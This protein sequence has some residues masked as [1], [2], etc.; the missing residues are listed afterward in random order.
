MTSAF[1]T[2]LAGNC[3]SDTCIGNSNFAF[4]EWKTVSRSI[5]EVLT[6]NM[7]NFS[8][9]MKTWLNNHASDQQACP[10]ATPATS[11]AYAAAAK[12]KHIS[13]RRAPYGAVSRGQHPEQSLL[14]QS[15]TVATD[16]SKSEATSLTSDS[17][18]DHICFSCEGHSGYTSELWCLH[19]N[20][21]QI[22][23]CEA[24][25][26]LFQA[27]HGIQHGEISGR[28]IR[29]LQDFL[30]EFLRKRGIRTLTDILAA[31]NKICPTITH[32]NAMMKGVREHGVK[33]SGASIDIRDKM[34][35]SKSHHQA[36]TGSACKDN[37]SEPA[38]RSSFTGNSIITHETYSGVI[39]RMSPKFGF[40]YCEKVKLQ[41]GNDVF[42]SSAKAP[43]GCN[44]GDI[45]V[46]ELMISQKGQPQA[47]NLRLQSPPAQP[48]YGYEL[49]SKAMPNLHGKLSKELSN[50][51][52]TSCSDGRASAVAVSPGQSF[53]GVV[54]TLTEK[55][56]FLTCVEVITQYGSDVYFPVWAL[57][58]WYGVGDTLTFD[59][60]I[61]HGQPQA[62]NLR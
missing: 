43:L 41:Y 37:E 39:S 31:T 18:S 14:L 9:T 35:Y 28:S 29:E 62:T 13:A 12:G 5:A 32:S 21:N 17:V 55:F 25:L 42:F 61:K 53:T 45:I 16:T 27:I 1:I 7:K 24:C 36:T 40:I 52:S 56:G 57:P 47:K 30:T 11:S 44:V 26:P 4:H 33:L 38:L 22:Y 51:H 23:F 2:W 8:A 34:H 6:L 15:S 20:S 46:F 48:A 60:M 58:H 3:S 19:V 50:M 10:V 54:K 59:L 49:N